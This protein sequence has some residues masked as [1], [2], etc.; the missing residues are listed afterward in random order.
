MQY[1]TIRGYA[2]GEFVEQRSRFIGQ[3]APVTSAEE[4]AAFVSEI[5]AAHR[6]ARHNVFAYVLLDGMTRRCSDDGEP[7]GTGG[8]PA[9]DVLVRE[10][11]TGAAVVVTRYFGG[12]LL[13]AGGLIR[14][15]SHGAKLAVD[16]ADI[17]QMSDCRVLRLEMAYAWYG[18]VQRIL[19]RYN[20]R[21]QDSDFGAAVRLEVIIRAERV[22]AFADEIA[23]LCAGSVP[24]T[25]LSS[26]YAE[27][28]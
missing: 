11:L 10:G 9:L 7:S 25:E 20:A 6:D 15:Y 4:A 28:N 26:V 22:Q 23:E 3:I 27:L 17:V 2:S 13:G 18:G 21:I 5:K 14:A 16:A 12:I 8:V 19:P 24:I 1:K